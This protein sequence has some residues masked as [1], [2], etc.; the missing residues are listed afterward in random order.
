MSV[1]S[2]IGSCILLSATL[3]TGAGVYA[4][5]GTDQH[6]LV[7][8]DDIARNLLKN[9]N[10]EFDRQ[11]ELHEDQVRQQ[12]SKKE[13]DN[14]LKKPTGTGPYIIDVIFH[15]V[16][17]TAQIS[18]LGGE[19][20]IQE[21]VNSQMMV[22]NRDWNAQNPD[23]VN[24]P[25]PFKPLFGNMNV[26][27]RLATKKPDG[28]PTPGYEIITTTKATSDMSGGNK[29]STVLSDAKYASNGGADAWDPD[30]Y[31]NVWVVNLNNP[32]SGSGYI[33]AGFATPP[34][35]PPWDQFPVAEQGTAI[36]YGTFGKRSA[37]ANT[38][39]PVVKRAGRWFTKPAIS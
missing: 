26:R 6:V 28:Q 36:H 16:L 35:Y 14:S 37:R 4:Q 34:R 13:Q 22:L 27:F 2:K 23:S 33:I 9:N 18:Q 31:Y 17:N 20:G 32:G 5:A 12:I 21:R 3:W 1:I 38:L 30:K 7:C 8:G 25:A 24:I 19:A 29:G 10:P 15:I 39:Y 11:L